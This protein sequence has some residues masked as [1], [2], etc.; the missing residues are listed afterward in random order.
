MK[1]GSSNTEQGRWLR[2]AG[3]WPACAL[4]A[5]LMLAAMAPGAMAQGA[6]P[7]GEPEEPFSFRQDEELYQLEE[8]VSLIAGSLNKIADKVSILAINSLSFGKDVG[9]EFRQK[10]RVIFLE[11]LLDANPAVKLV[12]C[13]ECDRLQ[14]RIV[15]GVL[16]LQ[17]GIPSGE[18]RQELARKLGVQGFIDI[19][20][21]REGRQLTVYIQVVE[22]ETGAII[23]V[24]EITGRRAPRRDSLTFSFGE[25][26]LPI[27]V[28]GSSTDHRTIVL[29][30]RESLQISERMSF[31]IELAFYLDN[32]ENNPDPHID[33]DLGAV[34]APTL[35]YDMLQFSGS[36]SR[37]TGYI[38]LGKFISP[39]LE[40]ANLIKAGVM[41]IVGDELEVLVGYNYF[42]DTT[43]EPEGSADVELGGGGY[44]IRFGYRF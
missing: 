10:A 17:K 8:A 29:A 28:G 43:L 15:R 6:S 30:V 4:A 21:F 44:E 2:A 31:G 1:M 42:Q 9:G 24:E 23:L 14:T 36:A 20:V 32:N 40:Y 34:L 26:I 41:F 5:W 16:K 38:G 33:L 11:K 37:I 19:G 39:Q 22:A 18:A 27:S 13:Q 7:T 35:G 3:M 25:M 12:Q